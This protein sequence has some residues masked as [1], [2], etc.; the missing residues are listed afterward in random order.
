MLND[1]IYEMLRSDEFY[2]SAVLFSR[3]FKLVKFR[4]GD[5]DANN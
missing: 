1:L 2:G 3:N 4:S 5:F